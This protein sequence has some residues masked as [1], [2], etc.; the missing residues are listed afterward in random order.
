[1]QQAQ[2]VLK[3]RPF[4][5]FKWDAES[6]LYD[7]RTPVTYNGGITNIY[8]WQELFPGKSSLTTVRAVH[9]HKEGTHLICV[10]YHNKLY[11]FPPNQRFNNKN[12]YGY[13][14]L[15]LPIK[16]NVQ[17]VAVARNDAGNI[18]LFYP[19]KRGADTPLIHL[20]LDQDTGD[21]EEQ[22]IEV[23]LPTEA[24][25]RL[26]TFISYSTDISLTDSAGVPLSNTAVT[27]SASDRT[28]VTINNATYSVDAVAAAS[29]TTALGKLTITHQTSGLSVPDLWIH[30]DKLIP[31]DQV[32]VL[33]QYANGRDDKSLPREMQSVQARLAD[34]SGP[35]LADAKDASSPPKYLLKDSFR[36]NKQSV[37]NLAK[38][39]SA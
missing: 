20:T 12:T 13:D 19:Q 16:E 17:W 35:E 23:E 10:D 9:D 18:E 7:M 28:A 31:S 21:W 4:L 34:V 27:I 2:K 26:E 33:Q 8:T 5:I 32:L 11:H 25:N 37:D 3:N 22:E 38:S 29:V 15:P 14:H 1:M 30:V 36:T 24:D 39:T 6:T